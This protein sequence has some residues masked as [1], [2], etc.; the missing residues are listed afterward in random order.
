M[1]AHQRP[2]YARPHM[3]VSLVPSAQTASMNQ[4]R[5]RLKDPL[6]L[7][8]LLCAVGTLGPVGSGH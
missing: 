4:E 7:G 2:N 8:L 6:P 5:L 1:E 3:I